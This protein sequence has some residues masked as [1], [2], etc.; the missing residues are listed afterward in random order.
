M[1]PDNIPTSERLVRVETKVESIIDLLGE[2]KDDL[3]YLPSRIEFVDVKDDIDKVESSTKEMVG[4]LRGRLCKV[5]NKTNGIL[6]KVGVVA[7]VLGMV[8]S[9]IAS[10]LINYVIG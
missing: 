8:F 2:I 4:D 7:G 3:K 10:V 9:A 6:I 1:P 5:E